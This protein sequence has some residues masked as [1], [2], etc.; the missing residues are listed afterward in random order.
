MPAVVKLGSDKCVPCREMNPVMAELA[1]HYSGKVVFLM[2]DVYNNQDLAAQYGVQAIPRIL[3][4][5][6]SG[7]AVA[8]SEGYASVNEM[9]SFIS[10]S[11]ILE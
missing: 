1:R 3:F 10:R 4:L 6:A 5:N 9:K 8:Y 7:K 2:V 11:G